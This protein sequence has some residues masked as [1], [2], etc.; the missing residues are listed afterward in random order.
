[1][2]LAVDAFRPKAKLK[3]GVHLAED[4]LEAG[5][6]AVRSRREVLSAGLCCEVVGDGALIAG[7]RMDARRARV[8]KPKGDG[9][10]AQEFVDE[11]VGLRAWH[12]TEVAVKKHKNGHRVM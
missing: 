5:G 12:G 11:V 10:G 9:R 8:A 3:T 2:A 4:L 6:V 7:E 1:M